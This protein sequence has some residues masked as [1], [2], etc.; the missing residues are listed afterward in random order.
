MSG[1][2]PE[3]VVIE[4]ANSD[5]SD[6]LTELW[7][8]LATDQRQHESHLR[9]EGNKPQIHETMLQHIVSGTAFVARYA[10]QPVEEEIVGFV[11]FGTES[12]KYNQDSFR[13]IVHNIYVK[14]EAREGGIGT[15]LLDVAERELESRGVD[16]IGLQAMADND[17]AISFYRRRGYS[18]HRIELEKP[19]NDDPQDSSEG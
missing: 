18:P 3:N 7:V 15:E 17:A 12:G 6:V 13:G 1:E 10:E 5:D 9:A 2:L 19:I 8:K 4:R 14:P 16:V 11:T